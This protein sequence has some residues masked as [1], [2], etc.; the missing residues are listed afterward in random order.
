MKSRYRQAHGFHEWFGIYDLETFDGG[1]KWYAMKNTPGG[2]RHVSGEAERLYPG[3]LSEHGISEFQNVLGAELPEMMNSSPPLKD[4]RNACSD[5][6]DSL[7]VASQFARLERD[8]I[9][10]KVRKQ[11]YCRAMPVL[12]QVSNFA[13]LSRKNQAN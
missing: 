8:F 2:G 13:D 10:E 3:L 7:S 6:E 5:D 11:T 1:L 9:R 12:Q 4:K